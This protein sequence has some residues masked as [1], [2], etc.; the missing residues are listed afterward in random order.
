MA[1]VWQVFV[2]FQL[3]SLAWVFFRARTIDD[4]FCLIGNMG[5]NLNLPVRMLSS[6]FST[7][8]SF[9]F[10]LVFVGIELV[11]Y[12]ADRKGVDLVRAIPPV[13][14]YPA[15]AAGLLMI[16]LFGVSSNQFIYFQF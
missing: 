14:R 6:Q 16:S 9:V 4:A 15:Y 3:V 13:V 5:I 8:L 10:A 2:T 1:A 11:T 7:A 12:W